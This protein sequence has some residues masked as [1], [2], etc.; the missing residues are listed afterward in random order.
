MKK[1]NTSTEEKSKHKNLTKLKDKRISKEQQITKELPKEV[2][3]MWGERQELILIEGK[4][5]TRVVIPIKKVR[6][7][8]NRKKKP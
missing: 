5:V 1:A 8:C 3:E 6:D 2:E 4:I 7:K